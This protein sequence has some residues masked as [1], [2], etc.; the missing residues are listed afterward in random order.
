MCITIPSSANV[1]RA[2]QWAVW[3]WLAQTPLRL[4]GFGGMLFL[5]L[6][7]L[8]IRSSSE[9]FSVWQVYNLLLLVLPALLLGPLLAYLPAQLKVTPLRYVGYG[10][11]FF[12]LLFGQL[13]FLVV[14]L[15]GVEPGL[16]YL[17]LQAMAWSMGLAFFRQMLASSYRSDLRM[18]WSL[19]F[20]VLAAGTAGLV[21]GLGHRYF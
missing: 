4:F 5:G 19:W 12:L 11:L 3:H 17:L 15:R 8:P 2:R 1:K 21:F 18:G 9:G 14:R 10:A 20:V 7:L 13:A 6:A 16:T